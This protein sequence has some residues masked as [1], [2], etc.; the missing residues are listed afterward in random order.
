MFTYNLVEV[1]ALNEERRDRD[2]KVIA[3]PPYRVP[4]YSLTSRGTQYG[5]LVSVFIREYRNSWFLY[6]LFGGLMPLGLLFLYKGIR[7]GTNPADAIFVMGGSLTSGIVL[8]PMTMLMTRVGWWRQMRAFDYW[9]ALP[10]PKVVFVLAVVTV[11]L[12]FSL[13]GLLLVYLLGGPLI[14]LSAVGLLMLLPV[15][16]LAALSLAGLGAFLGLYAGDAQTANQLANGIIGV[17]VFLSPMLIPLERLPLP[18]RVIAQLN[19]ATYAADAFRA[20]LSGDL[21]IALAIDVLALSAFAA[22]FLLL[23]HYKLDWRST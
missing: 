10:L 6:I 12:L 3:H 7:G 21:T 15:M 1:P 2:I 8:G 16:P 13:P 14:G 20:V 19:P 11:S 17:V 9:A 22:A 4:S 5:Q 18:L 23:V